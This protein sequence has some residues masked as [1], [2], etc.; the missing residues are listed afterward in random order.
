MVI[1]IVV[2]GPD[3][4]KVF[5]I[6]GDG[7]IRIGRD[8]DLEL[9]DQKVSRKHLEIMRDNGGWFVQ[10]QGSRTDALLNGEKIESRMALT[11]GATLRLGRT[12]LV[13]AVVPES[14]RVASQPHGLV[15]HRDGR[16]RR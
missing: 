7:P 12:T 13:F 11:N 6:D 16:P 15:S 3:Q 9:K 1:L 2:K 5:H 4:G 10:D 8:L 14:A